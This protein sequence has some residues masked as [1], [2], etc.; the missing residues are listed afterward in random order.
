MLIEMPTQLNP[1]LNHDRMVA[2]GDGG[3]RTFGRDGSQRQCL[4]IL[5]RK[6]SFLIALI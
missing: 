5:D 6:S 2:P 3:N 4:F 1:F